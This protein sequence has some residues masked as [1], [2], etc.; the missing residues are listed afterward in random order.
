MIHGIIIE[1]IFSNGTNTKN[2]SKNSTLS[3]RSFQTLR[4]LLFSEDFDF[5][6]SFSLYFQKNYP[7]IITVN[8]RE[9]FIQLVET[10]KPQ[11]IVIDSLLNE[12]ILGLIKNIRQLTSE[13]KIFVLT[14]LEIDKQPIIDEIKNLVTK[15]YFQPIDLIEIYQMLNLYT[16]D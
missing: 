4:L 16:A 3:I 14:S 11:I 10:I 5:A 15:I 2:N 8:D 7:K 1:K 6:Q 13:S 12:Q 9:L